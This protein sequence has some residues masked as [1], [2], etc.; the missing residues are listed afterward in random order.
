MRLWPIASLALLGLASFSACG[1]DG[2]ATANK[3]AAAQVGERVNVPR[4]RQ[5]CE[6]QLGG[7]VDSLDAM[8]R[9]LAV[10]LTYEEYIDQVRG[11]RKVYGEVPV[12]RLSVGCLLAAG[13][14]GE[15]A[16]NEYIDAANAWGDCLATA[17]CDTGSVEP[18]LQRGWEL[19]SDQLS[20]ARDGLRG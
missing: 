10:G 12:D 6:V 17:G 8:R 14:P 20:E 11:L 9:R 13:A 18:K 7:L 19:A 1:D 4:S 3:G 2:T 16:F 5:K 15:R